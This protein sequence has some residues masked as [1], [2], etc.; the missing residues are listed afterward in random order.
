MSSSVIPIENTVDKH[1]QNI[2]N[3]FLFLWYFM[4]IYIH[5]SFVRFITVEVSFSIFVSS[6]KENPCR[7]GWA[8]QPRNWIFLLPQTSNYFL[9]P[10]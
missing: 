4:I 6:Q 7:N 2:L 8:H 5:L 9:F 3:I 10:I 1:I